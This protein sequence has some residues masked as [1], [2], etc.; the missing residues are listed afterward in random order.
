VAASS[1]TQQRGQDRGGQTPWSPAWASSSLSYSAQN[2]MRFD[3]RD[4]EDKGNMF[5]KLTVKETIEGE[6]AM[7]ARFGRRLATMRVASGGALALRSSSTTS[8]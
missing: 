2:M 8:P 5:Y 3:L 1:S 6:Q 4:L 7:V